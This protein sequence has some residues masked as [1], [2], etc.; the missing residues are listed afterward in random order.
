MSLL[1]TTGAHRATRT[2]YTPCAQTTS[3]PN[4]P[5]TDSSPSPA[6]TNQT[7][8]ASVVLRAIHDWLDQ[9]APTNLAE[10]VGALTQLEPRT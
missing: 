3:T 1:Q 4:P 6:G 9:P 5:M 2:R 7:N 10:E 8:D